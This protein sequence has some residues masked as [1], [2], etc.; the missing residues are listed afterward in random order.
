[1]TG[2]K[3]TR[4]TVTEEVTV[5]ARKGHNLWILFGPNLYDNLTIADKMACASIIPQYRSPFIII[6]IYIYKIQ[7]IIKLSDVVSG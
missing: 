6:Y 4:K 7:N 5:M 2:K 3:V 1:M